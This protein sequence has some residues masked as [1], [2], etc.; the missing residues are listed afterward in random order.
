MRNIFLFVKIMTKDEKKDIKFEPKHYNEVIWNVG[1]AF[2]IK[3]ISK[4]LFL[5]WKNHIKLLFLKNILIS[6]IKSAIREAAEKKIFPQSM[7]FF[8]RIELIVLKNRRENQIRPTF[9]NDQ[10]ESTRD[11]FSKYKF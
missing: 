7:G 2:G 8:K 1:Q 9:R 4:E 3:K 11:L 6:E 5:I 10:M